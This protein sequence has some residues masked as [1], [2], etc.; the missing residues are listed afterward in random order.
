[1]TNLT[2]S[3][4]QGADFTVLSN[5]FI[6]E[7]MVLANDAQIKIYLYLLRMSSA[8]LPFGISDIV[9]HFNYMEQDVLRAL[10]YW[11]KKD[12][13]SLEFDKEDHITAI[14]IL[15]FPVSH[16]TETAA[17]AAAAPAKAPS[18]DDL[19]KQA[20]IVPLAPK[21]AAG[22]APKPSYSPEDLMA[23]K[24]NNETSQIIFIA[25]SYIGRPLSPSDIQVLLY[26]YDSLGFSADLIDYLI[27]YCVGRG[28]K[29]FSYIQKV[30]MNWADSN[31]TTIEQ[32]KNQTGR[33]DKSV[34]TIMKAL[35]KNSDP[36]DPEIAFIRKWSEEWG[37][38]QKIIL[39][40]CEKTV[41]STD[42]HRFEY[43]NGI[44]SKWHAAGVFS[45]QDI[46]AFE[47]GHNAAAKPAKNASKSTNSLHAN[48]HSY[49]FQALEQILRSN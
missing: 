30:A 3:L 15:P 28:K 22:P 17:I 32:A 20:E 36:T 45:E 12:L 29:Q 40:A 31:I 24:T 14:R 43:T 27:Q 37:F 47:A 10:N 9:E 8:G 38:S 16:K 7:Y 1:M 39:K 42:R 4:D 6:D 26:I 49:D 21:L 33:Y 44:L 11:E 23:F 41:L 25:E 48:R 34:Y 35:G 13:L 19:T 5:R 2:V 46:E 18:G